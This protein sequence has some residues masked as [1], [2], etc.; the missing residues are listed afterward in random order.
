M[1]HTHALG[2]PTL[3]NVHSVVYGIISPLVVYREVHHALTVLLSEIIARA[4]MMTMNVHN[5]VCGI[6]NPLVASQE[7]LRAAKVLICEI[8]ARAQTTRRMNG[9]AVQ[10]LKLAIQTVAGKPEVISTAS[11]LVSSCQYSCSVSKHVSIC[12]ERRILLYQHLCCAVLPWRR[13][14]ESLQDKLRLY[15]YQQR[16]NKDKSS[17]NPISFP[18]L[19]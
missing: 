11:E 1:I 4:L 10:I 16:V 15:T 13:L 6:V 18:L 14:R 12:H 3:L 17:K 19:Y 5:V 8:I 2:C 7:V 9:T